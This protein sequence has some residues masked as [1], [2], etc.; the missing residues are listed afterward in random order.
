MDL[1]NSKSYNSNIINKRLSING[2]DISTGT[3]LGMRSEN[4]D[5]I[6]IEYLENR[7]IFILCDGHGGSYLSKRIP[8]MIVNKFL[9][10]IDLS[11]KNIVENIFK[12]ID[13][14]LYNEY[15]LKNKKREGTT[16]SIIL[17]IDNAIIGI[18]LGDSAYLIN[19]YDKYEY[20]F[21]H[22]PNN[23]IEIARIL[24]AGHKI[25]KVGKD[26]R[27]DGRLSLSRSFGDYTYKFCNNK[28]NNVNGAVSCIPNFE[29]Y[30]K[31]F[32]FIILGSDGFW[33]F[34][35]KKNVL[36]YLK[37]NIRNKST[38]LIVSDLIK[39]AIQNGSKDNISIIVIKQ[40]G[41]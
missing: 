17:I 11:D 24:E 5:N 31:D 15:Y 3:Y 30:E 1:H 2:L 33:D 9:K 27:I 26:F 16:C 10:G 6:T 38:S 23:K 12:E 14:Y 37:L 35:N 18:N 39:I 28:F 41:K 13:S 40:C 34:V 36:T 25:I 32:D 20:P 21:I 4:Q 29:R 8:N 22:R 7:N 19:S